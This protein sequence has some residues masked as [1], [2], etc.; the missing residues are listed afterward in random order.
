MSDR[1]PRDHETV[2]C[3]PPRTAEEWKAHLYELVD[4][5]VDQDH[6]DDIVD[7]IQQQARREA[8]EEAADAINRAAMVHKADHVHAGICRRLAQ[9]EQT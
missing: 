8:L 5:T 9:Q 6:V 7:Q 3:E 1:R 2:D 4:R